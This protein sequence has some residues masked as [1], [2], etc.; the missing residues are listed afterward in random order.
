MLAFIFG[1]K[2]NIRRANI[3]RKKLQSHKR[4]PYR[5]PFHKVD[6]HGAINRPRNP[7]VN[8]KADYDFPDAH[9]LIPEQENTDR[10]KEKRHHIKGDPIAVHAQGKK[11]HGKVKI[12]FSLY[13]C[14]KKA[15]AKNK[16]MGKQVAVQRPPA[17][18]KMPWINCKQK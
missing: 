17:L 14:H 6:Q 18:H 3:P 15:H 9:F 16:H 4:K 13:S 11:Y 7:K 5:I 12:R 2:Q 10:K 1:K 8:Q